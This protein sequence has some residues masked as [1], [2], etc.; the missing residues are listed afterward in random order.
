[1]IERGRHLLMLPG[2]TNVPERVQRAMLRPADDFAGPDFMA[3]AESCFA[4]LRRVFATEG[5]VVMCTTNGHGAWEMALVNLFD[6]GDALLVPGSGR[7][8]MSWAEMAEA[9]GFTVETTPID[10]RR[11][12][13]PAA[14]EAVLRAD[15]RHRIKGVLLVHTETATGARTDLVAVRRAIDAA[16]HPALLVVDAIASLAVE[17]FAMDEMGI[18]LAIAASQKGLMLPVGLAFLA[19]GEK[20]RSTTLRCRYPRRYWD[21]RSRRG[22]QS[23]MWFH[24]TPPVS[25]VQ[26]LRAA[27]DM[28][29]EEG[30]PAVIE[31][32]ARLAHAVRACVT[33]WSEAGAMELNACS[34]PSAPTP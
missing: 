13:D 5:E 24:G 30:L 17:P 12:V 4:D 21:L 14:V 34:Q 29:L 6:P 33:A 15:R 23:Y 18:D 11:A 2:P 22:A 31:R 10:W 20:A 25:H 27:L 9:L 16:R 1:M 8:S 28:I 32:H 7:F 3:V 26:G 19:L